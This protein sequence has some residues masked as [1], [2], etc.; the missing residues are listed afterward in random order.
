MGQKIDVKEFYSECMGL[1]A[2]KLGDRAM[3]RQSLLEAWWELDKCPYYR[4][5]PSI[6]PMM[7]RLKLSV[8]T[9]MIKLPSK[10]R[11]FAVFLPKV[12]H[13]LSFDA[14]DQHHTIRSLI[15]GP[16]TLAK[17]GHTWKGISIWVDFGETIG[18]VERD[19]PKKTL[20]FPVLT[21]INIPVE[22]GMT[23]ETAAN[24]LHHDPSA[25]YGI[26][27]PQEIKAGIIK[28]IC[29]LCL[30]E[31]DPA[32]IEPDVLDRDRTKY[33]AHPDPSIVERAIRRGKFG[34]NVGRKI[35][36]MPHVRGP[37]PL[38]LYWT[39]KGRTVPLIR[40][41]KGCIVHREL[42]TKVSTIEN[43]PNGKYE[44]E[45]DEE[46]PTEATEAAANPS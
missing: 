25:N 28:L 36:V 41:R 34:W 7:L 14:N 35:E 23:V 3:F 1:S 26:I 9:G 45:A 37:S 24:M 8:D 13:Q 38:A 17:G 22:D 5:Y 43:Y 39:G 4:V 30:L 32:I 42:V 10:L 6:I 19:A 40:Y 11:T 12:D 44:I 16:V 31:N 2:Y 27:M 21:Y 33:E 46:D 15:C 18:M 20:N 29:T